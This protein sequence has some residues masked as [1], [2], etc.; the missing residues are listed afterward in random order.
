MQWEA[1]RTGRWSATRPGHLLAH[2]R[3][4]CAAF[5][6]MTLRSVRLRSGLPARPMATEPPRHRYRGRSTARAAVARLPGRTGHRSQSG[7]P[8]RNASRTQNR[9]RTA[10]LTTLACKRSSNQ[11]S[12][13]RHGRRWT[14]MDTHGRPVPGGTRCSAGS[15]RQY[16]GSGRR[17]ERAARLSTHVLCLSI[18]RA[19]R[20][21]WYR[22]H[23]LI[24]GRTLV[25]PARP[26]DVRTSPDLHL[27]S[28]CFSSS[29]SC[30]S[31]EASSSWFGG[32][33]ATAASR[34]GQSAI[35]GPA[36]RLHAVDP[37]LDVPP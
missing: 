11:V 29:R 32:R 27:V 28:S 17:G 23:V 10:P 36:D 7:T 16:L 15:P 2:T 14:L 13:N 5:V 22:T 34:D 6:R 12:N 18:F 1:L 3:P 30:A 37:V 35:G 4:G 21:T 26:G 31:S 19:R 20:G 25:G 33:M 8:W 9:C 24:G